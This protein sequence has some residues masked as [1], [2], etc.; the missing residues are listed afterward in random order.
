M[1]LHLGFLTAGGVYV[2]DVLPP[3]AAAAPA[4][5]VRGLE[6]SNLCVSAE[7]REDGTHVL[8]LRLS[9]DAEGPFR[10]AFHLD[11]PGQPDP[12]AVHVTA[13]VMSRRKGTP[14]LKESVRCVGF[15]TDT[16]T[17]AASDAC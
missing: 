14:G 16:D 6:A 5:L 17:E 2:T 11:F 1:H 15:T 8:T 12:V 7:Q 13:T 3:R 10:T 4:P 9:A